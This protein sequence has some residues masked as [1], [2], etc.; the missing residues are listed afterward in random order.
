MYIYGDTTVSYK[1]ADERYNVAP[2]NKYVK[3]FVT[4]KIVKRGYKE[5][6]NLKTRCL[7]LV[8]ILYSGPHHQAP[9]NL[10]VTLLLLPKMDLGLFSEPY[11]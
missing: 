1:F 9:V 5:N 2:C 6:L 10:S 7:Q 3:S 11:W 4:S 8:F